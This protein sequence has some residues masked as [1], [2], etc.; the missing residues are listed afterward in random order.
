MSENTETAIVLRD[1]I[2]QVINGILKNENMEDASLEVSEA[3]AKGDNY[4]GKIYRVKS[5]DKHGKSMNLIVKSALAFKTS[6]E[7]FPIGLYFER[8]TFAYSVI[9]PTMCELQD[10]LLIPNKEKLHFAK[11]YDSIV[12]PEKEIIVLEDLK[13]DGYMLYD[14]QKSFD[15]QHLEI[16]MKTL[17]R[18]HA[19][20]FVLKQKKPALFE[21]LTENVSKVMEY[22]VNI[23]SIFIIAKKACFGL[24]ECAEIK[25]KVEDNFSDFMAKFRGFLDC[26]NTEPYNVICHGDCWINNFMFKYEDDK[27]A[28]MKFVDWQIVRLASP[29]TDIAYMMFSSTD[30]QLRSDCYTRSLDLYYETLDKNIT[31]MGC[32]TT[33]CYPLEAFQDQI[34]STMPFGLVAATML[35]PVILCDKEN[36]PDLDKNPEDYDDNMYDAMIS[37][38]CRDRFNGV[39]KDMIS[40]GLI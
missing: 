4:I 13:V 11:Y 31:R 28:D 30:E 2:V 35:L 24:I 21:Q 27:V 32:K 20:S 25:Q 15:R 19:M 14:R 34:K 9:H 22:G 5:N 29:I 40:F 18:F 17:A 8:E 12:E 36:A 23:D 39:A 33:E 37:Q 3:T 7:T 6:R 1:D 10:E 16:V 38:L 26:K